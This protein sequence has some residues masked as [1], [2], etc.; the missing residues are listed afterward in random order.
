M[1]TSGLLA[2]AGCASYVPQPLDPQASARAWQSRSLDDPGLRAYVAGGGHVGPIDWNVDALV[3]AAYYL[4]PSLDAARAE[5]AAAAAGV[6]VAAERPNP[7]LQLPFERAT[8]P[9]PGDSPYTLGLGLDIPLETAARRGYRIDAARAA[10]R[11]AQLDVGAAAWTVRSKVRTQ[12]LAWHLQ[13]HRIDLLRQRRDARAKAVAL[14]ERRVALGAASSPVL[15]DAQAALRQ[16]GQDLVQARSLLDDARAGTAEAI[17]LPLRALDGLTPDL[18]A[19]D[20]APSWSPS[21]PW[22]DAMAREQAVLNRADVQAALARYAEAQAALQTEVAQQLPTLHLGPGFLFDAGVRKFQL[23]L[24]G[25]PL[26]LF[27]GNRAAIAH[28]DARRRALATRFDAL[29]DAALAR[30]DRAMAAL[31]HAIAARDATREREAA[32][33]GRLQDAQR[34]FDAGDID[35]LALALAGEQAIDGRLAAVEAQAALQQRVGELEDALERPLDAGMLPAPSAANT[36]LSDS[37][38][39]DSSLPDSARSPERAPD[40]IVPAA[41]RPASSPNRTSSPEMP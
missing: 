14:L 5:A 12:L 13:A 25:I 21:P 32:D 16:A 34:R 18:D 2:L 7:S 26:P 3:R 20:R 9:Q 30:A 4:D 40:T 24:T 29:Q 38:L 35:R 28:A 1:T 27:H 41:R 31:R 6:A 23:P 33:A 22:P 10:G 11:A 37:S 17:G 39:P 36:W 8:N 15:H 19:F